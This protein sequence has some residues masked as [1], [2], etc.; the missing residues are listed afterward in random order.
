L[1]AAASDATDP[2]AATRALDAFFAAMS[3]P[4]EYL[5]ATPVSG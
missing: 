3:A 1:I 5:C 2:E 4:A